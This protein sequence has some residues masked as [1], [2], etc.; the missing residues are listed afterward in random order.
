M[1][2]CPICFIEVEDYEITFDDSNGRCC[3]ECA[4]YFQGERDM[5]DDNLRKLEKEDIFYD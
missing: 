3:N 2:E 5:F 4:E 1:V